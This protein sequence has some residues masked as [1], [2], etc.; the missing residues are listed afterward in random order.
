MLKQFQE[1]LVMKSFTAFS[2]F[3]KSWDVY[4]RLFD[5][6]KKRDT[7]RLL[8]SLTDHFMQL[9]RLWDSVKGQV[10][11]ETE[12]RPR[13]E[14]QQKQIKNRV[15]RLGGKSALKRLL[16]NQQEFRDA[17]E[18]ESESVEG[19][20]AMKR[21]EVESVVNSSYQSQTESRQEEASASASS[22]K[23]VAASEMNKLLASFGAGLTNEQL[24]HE[25]VLDPEFELKPNKNDQSFESQVRAIAKKAFFDKMR[26]DVAENKYDSLAAV[27]TDIKQVR[28]EF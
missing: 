2:D 9:E 24:A 5:Q 26:Q 28:S 21:L 8:S 6:W 27:L 3:S 23:P 7:E 14:T 13:I 25:L 15:V 17:S 18:S 1:W 4:H 10:D 12:W 11:A 16:T 19:T 22:A 20:P